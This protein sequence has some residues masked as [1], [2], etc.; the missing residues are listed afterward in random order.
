MTSRD[1]SRWS[2]AWSF[3]TT[4]LRW[5]WS[6]SLGSEIQGSGAFCQEH[7]ERVTKAGGMCEVAGKPKQR[8]K[9]F[10]PRHP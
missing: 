6:R 4:F 2:V 10:G 5:N 1:P 7:L 9:A 3:M 8:V